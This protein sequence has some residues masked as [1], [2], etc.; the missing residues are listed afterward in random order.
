MQHVKSG[1]QYGAKSGIQHGVP[2]GIQHGKQIHNDENPC[3]YW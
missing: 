2:S 1:I 3:T